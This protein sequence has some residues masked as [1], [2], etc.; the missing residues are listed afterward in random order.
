MFACPGDIV[1]GYPELNE[2][3][4]NI[5]IQMLVC[6]IFSCIFLLADKHPKLNFPF[7]KEVVRLGLVLYGCYIFIDI[8]IINVGLKYYI[9][10]YQEKECALIVQVFI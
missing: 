8:S 10:D 2:K 7:S 4:E 1:E 9:I 3:I 6:H 5:R